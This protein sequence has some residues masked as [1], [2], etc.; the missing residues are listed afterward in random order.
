MWR[1]FRGHIFIL[2]GIEQKIYRG[3]FFRH[4]FFFSPFF[5]PP[6]ADAQGSLPPCPLP[7]DTTGFCSYKNHL[8]N[9]KARSG[10]KERKERNTMSEF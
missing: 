4:F 2:R 3:A 6:G 7:S 9:I 5:A 8:H 10:R 1:I